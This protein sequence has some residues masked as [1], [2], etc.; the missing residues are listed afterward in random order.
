MLKLSQ[1]FTT[2]FISNSQQ[3]QLCYNEQRTRKT[4]S[5]CEKHLHL[6]LV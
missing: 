1:V 5:D 6:Q 4:G 2:V 3:L